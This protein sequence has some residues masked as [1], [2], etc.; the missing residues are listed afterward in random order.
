MSYNFATEEDVR[1][2]ARS[3]L[4]TEGRRLNQAK[5]RGRLQMPGSI[6]RIGMT[7]GDGITARSDTTP[8]TGNVQLYRLDDAG[9]L[10]ATDD[11]EVVAKNLASTAVAADTYVGLTHAAGVWWV[12]WEDCG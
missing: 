1:R 11:D 12:I 7:D 9:D 6:T 4:V 5:P 10:E 3:V 2:I 8:G